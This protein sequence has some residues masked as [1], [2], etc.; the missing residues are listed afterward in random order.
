VIFGT[1]SIFWY[2]ECT[3][4]SCAHIY[5]IPYLSKHF[6]LTSGAKRHF[7]APS[8][9][10]NTFDSVTN[11]ELS[12]PYIIFDKTCAFRF[13]NVKSLALK[14]SHDREN[15]QDHPLR[16]KLIHRLKTIVSFQNLNHLDINL[17]HTMTLSSILKLLKNM[18]HSL[19]LKIDKNHLFSLINNPELCSYLKRIQKL[20]I[21]DRNSS[22]D[23]SNIMRLCAV[24]PNMKQLRCSLDN[25][26]T[27]STAL[28]E[29]SKLKEMKL[30]L[31][32]IV[33]GIMSFLEHGPKIVEAPFVV[34]DN[35]FF[36]SDGFHD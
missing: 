26:I 32:E 34:V 20:E 5:T 33:S 25:R 27:F 35:P 6:E 31:I 2:T 17:C 28:C 19:S 22:V 29:L 14:M 21:I 11:L 15:N 24:F 7:H 36:F 1:S 3:I 23:K 4:E 10:A 8:S 30:F 16:S 18:P 12:S 9:N 13:S